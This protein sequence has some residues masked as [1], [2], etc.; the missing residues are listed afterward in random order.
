M[1]MKL[2]NAEYQRLFDE[3]DFLLWREWDP[4]GGVPRNEYERYAPQIFQLK[5]QKA[6]TDAIAGALLQFETEYI[7]VEGNLDN[8]TRVAELIKALSFNVKAADDKNR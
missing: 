5:I 6:N 3:I 4:I 1:R 7:G 2:R 8:C